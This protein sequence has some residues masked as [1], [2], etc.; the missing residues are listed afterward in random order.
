MDF[1]Q[2]GSKWGVEI[3]YIHEKSA[4]GTAGALGILD[5][6]P[7]QSFIVMN[8][9]VLTNVNYQQLLDFHQEHSSQATM[10]VREYDFH[11]PYGVVK[12][13]NHK[14]CGIEEKPIQT[15][16][17]NAGIYVFEPQIINLIP[18]NIPFDMPDLFKM[19]LDQKL[20]NVVFPIREYWL[21]VG[22]MNDFEQANVDY[23]R[24]FSLKG[25]CLKE[26]LT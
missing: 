7:Q 24:I 21:D 25:N 17:V 10:C 9:D 15:V 8:G 5:E 18:K 3:R 23:E 26:E 4:M 11:I 19:A 20:N 14:L 1:F 12:I 6:Q 2:D 16:F 22:Q 13:E